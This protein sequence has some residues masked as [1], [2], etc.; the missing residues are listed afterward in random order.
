MLAGLLTTWLTTHGTDAAALFFHLAAFAAYACLQRRRALR[1]SDATLQ[2]QQASVRSA[3]VHEILASGNGILGVQTL[4]NTTT[5][6]LFFASNTIFL[7]FGV[8]SL[9]SQGRLR[10]TF[11]LLDLGDASAELV[12][13]T[14]LSAFFCFLSAI[15]MFSHASVSIG[16]KSIAPARVL[17]Q[18][19]VAW[20]YQSLGVRGYYFAAPLLCWLFGTPWLV[21]ADLAAL[22]FM[23]LFDD[24]KPSP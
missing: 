16:L 17:A 20:R 4:R 23:H 13:L 14:L 9:A 24:A 8:L 5:A 19:E 7:V 2:A 21:L 15:R 11:G 3:W 12:Q 1:D 10:E 22:T 18:L 6:T